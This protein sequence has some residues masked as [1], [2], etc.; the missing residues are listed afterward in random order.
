MIDA[1]G[2]LNIPSGFYHF[3]KMVS[4]LRNASSLR[5][6]EM[7]PFPHLPVAADGLDQ[8]VRVA[9]EEGRVV[10]GTVGH[11]YEN[12]W[13]IRGLEQ[14]LEDLLERPAWAECVLDRIAERARMLAVAAAQAGA[15]YLFTGDDVASQHGMIFSPDVWRR[16]IKPRWKQV[17]D[18]ARDISPDIAIWYHSDGDISAIVPELIEIGVTIL[19][20][21]QPECMDVVALKRRYGSRLVFDGTIGTQTTMPFGSPQEVRRTVMDRR[22][23]LGKDGALILS[24]THVLEPEVPEENVDAFCEACRAG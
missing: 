23:T 22:R 10:V 19:N 9:R 2:V 12:A 8:E 17:Y 16:F 13:Q 24:P 7:F 20:P 14:F 18:A 5:E 11:I 15:D 21:L 4:P 6:I 1:R 3:K